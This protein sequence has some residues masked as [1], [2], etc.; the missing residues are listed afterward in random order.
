M[1]NINTMNNF[2][3][4]ATFQFRSFFANKNSSFSKTSFNEKNTYRNYI[5]LLFGE[6]NFLSSNTHM[7]VMS[8]VFLMKIVTESWNFS[9]SFGCYLISSIIRFEFFKHLFYGNLYFNKTISNEIA[10]LFTV[11]FRITPK[12]KMLDIFLS[13]IIGFISIIGIYISMMSKKCME[14][15]LCV[16]GK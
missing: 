7:T 16:L 9:F 8:V 15:L 2:Y 4:N 1:L 14:N 10:D 11:M 13:F 6:A 3:L 12:E 5:T